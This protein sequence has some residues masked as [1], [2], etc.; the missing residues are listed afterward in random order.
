M[1][2][3]SKVIIGETKTWITKDASDLNRQVK[4]FDREAICSDFRETNSARIPVE[5]RVALF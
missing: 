3:V 2:F 1:R 5:A 4:K